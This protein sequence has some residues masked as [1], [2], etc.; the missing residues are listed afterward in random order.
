MLLL[1]PPERAAPTAP[2]PPRTRHPRSF[3]TIPRSTSSFGSCFRGDNDPA[4]WNAIV[5]QDPDLFLFLGDNVYVDVPRR[6]RDAG[7]FQKKYDALATRPGWRTLRA[8]VPVLA[9][10]DDHDYGLN[11]AGAEYPLKDV[12]QTQFLNFF[13]RP[14]D[15]EAE[16]ARRER[17]GIYHAQTFGP[18]GRRV[19]VILLDT[20]FPPRAADPQRTPSEGPRALPPRRRLHLR[21][22]GR[23]PVGVAASATTPA[24]RRAGD[25]VE[26]PGRRR[27]ARLGNLGQPAPRARPAVPIDRRNRRRGRG[28]RQRRPP[29]AGVVPRRAPRRALPPVGRDLV[30]PGHPFRKKSPNPIARAWARCFAGPTSACCASTGP[31][32]APR[33]RW[34]A[35]A[36]TAT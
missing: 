7:D 32:I 35:A 18:A 6:P 31:P 15:P 19:Q 25:R 16:T 11:D 8:T 26:H 36:K 29:P 34:K 28:L 9:I 1:T 12:A 10:W 24:R 2:R 17:P 22:A 5:A 4:V 3:Q 27:R 20:R 30:G 33:S 21:H 14:V 13:T 23:S